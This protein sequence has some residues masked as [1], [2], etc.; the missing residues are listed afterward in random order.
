M[1][2]QV[3][4]KI[5]NLLPNFFLENQIIYITC[6]QGPPGQAGGQG[7]PGLTGPTGKPGMPGLPGAD[8]AVVSTCIRLKLSD[9]PSIVLSV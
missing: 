8:G 4:F 6:F 2:V 1:K 7:P 5:M 9:R 3:K